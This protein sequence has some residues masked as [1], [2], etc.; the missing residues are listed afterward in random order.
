VRRR[1]N[2]R[3]LDIAERLC[4]RLPGQAVHQIEIEGLEMLTGQLRGTLRFG[5]VVD[6][7]ERLR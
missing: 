1:K 7:A 5:G 6:A 4:Q 2:E 3:R